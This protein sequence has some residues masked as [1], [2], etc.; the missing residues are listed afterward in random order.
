MSVLDELYCLCL[1]LNLDL[2]SLQDK[3][4][5]NKDALKKATRY[6]HHKI[7]HIFLRVAV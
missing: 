6:V 7:L 3:A 1:S 4:D 2:D 5:K